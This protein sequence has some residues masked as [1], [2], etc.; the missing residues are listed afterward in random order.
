MA[1]SATWAQGWKSP[2]NEEAAEQCFGGP[3]RV[4][5]EVAVS[6][7][8]H[9]LGNQCMRLIAPGVALKLTSLSRSLDAFDIHARKLL[10]HSDL[11]AIAWVNIDLKKVTFTMFDK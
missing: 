4:T 8:G 1:C 11:R 7:G 6:L 5:A 9:A 10:N 2:C 3:E